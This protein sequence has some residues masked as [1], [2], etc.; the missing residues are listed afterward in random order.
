MISKFNISFQKPKYGWLYFSLLK[1]NKKMINISASGVW[2]PFY[3]YV[4][5]L[6]NLKNNRKKKIEFYIDQEGYDA[7]IT[8]INRGIYVYIET[9]TL[10]NK[11]KL[12]K[13]NGVFLKK[14]VIKEMKK[15]LLKLFNRNKQ[16]MCNWIYNFEFNK[17][18]LI[19]I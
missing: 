1:N 11:N 9:E 10:S 4:N 16:E 15:E 14:E 7:K 8:F 2:N 6:Y 19:R 17:G 18:K 13:A 3:D 5:V 12:P